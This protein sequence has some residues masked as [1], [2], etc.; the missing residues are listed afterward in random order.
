MKKEICLVFLIFFIIINLIYSVDGKVI[1]GETVTGE[2]VTGEATQSVG[3][4]I[5]IVV[6][7][8]TLIINS[9]KNETYLTNESFLLNYSVNNEE[10][11]WYS[12]DNLENIT[13]D[14]FITLNLSQGSHTLFLYANSSFGNITKKNVSFVVNSS[15]FLILDNEFD[16][17]N[18]EDNLFNIRR[19]KKGSST[20]FL[21][22]NFQELQNLSNIILEI[23]DFGKMFFNEAINLTDDLNNTDNLLDID[24]YI[25]ISNNRIEIDSIN[26]PNFDKPATL[27][28]YN[29]TF[30]NPRI[31]KDGFICSN[32]IC[33]L[34]NYSSGI[35]KF[36]VTGFSV[37]SAEETPSEEV[38]S[39]SSGGGSGGGIITKFYEKW[40][41]DKEEIKVSLKQGQT[42]RKEF[43]IEN[44]GTKKLKVNLENLKSQDFFII[45]E[46]SFELDVGET[47]KIFLD[48]IARED[49]IPD[50]YLG[51]ILLKT[52]EIEKEILI[53][54]EIES[55][56]SLFDVNIEIPREY[57]Q[58]FPGGSLLAT[59]NLFNLGGSKKVDV[60]V[61]Y[62]IKNEEGF[63]IVSESDSIAV[64][65]QVSFIEEF[66]ILENIPP[67]RY[68]LYIKVKY[69]N[70]I[71]SGSSW[72]KVV[73]KEKKSLF[74]FEF[75]I[76]FFLVFMIFLVYYYFK[77]YFKKK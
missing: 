7:F 25:N 12:L 28:F 54:I 8:P 49:V 74:S 47:K 5:M 62:S 36:N 37:Y 16:E 14:S 68:V 44:V 41:I 30:S 10:S 63:E 21:D 31:L 1:T 51:K 48:F 43:L 34:E 66:E 76:A 46:N 17:G 32:L 56:N 71:A 39:S 19:D 69:D 15:Y 73:G 23:P 70:Q 24:N 9:P 38:V 11:V 77:K 27:W 50:L 67:G 29:L 40:I 3:M 45:S 13:I 2:I 58:V 64:E 57:L 6:Y 65:T 75:F 55:K 60:I 18:F 20:D 22:Y 52:N 35:L 33:V 42:K 26:L 53:A 59:I 61:E 4:N 72:F